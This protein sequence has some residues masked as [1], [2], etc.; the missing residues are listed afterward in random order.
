MNRSIGSQL[1]A[2]LSVS[3]VVLFA[4]VRASANVVL[5]EST[6]GW[7]FS[8]AAGAGFNY[9]PG[10]TPDNGSTPNTVAF[11]PGYTA[12][13]TVD[14]VAGQTYRIIG[15]R[16]VDNTGAYGFSLALNGTT[17]LTELA[18][19]TDLSSGVTV[20]AMTYAG[21]YTAPTTTNTVQLLNGGSSASRVDYL[22]F[23]PTN[24]VF[25]DEHTSDLAYTGTAGSTNSIQGSIN[26]NA[27]DNGMALTGSGTVSGTVTLAP[28]TLYNVYASRNVHDT[29]NLGFRVNL[30]GNV[31]AL[32]YA[33]PDPI[34]PIAY[35]ND[36]AQEVL[37]G[38]FTA[39]SASTSVLLDIGGAYYARVDYLRFE[40]VPE[41]GCL[42]L[43]GCGSLLMTWRRKA[44]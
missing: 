44:A 20:Q 31:L 38:Q 5:D 4:G 7:V 6:P 16:V 28:G 2:A 39:A 21:Y 41:P 13:N 10:A 33:F 40:A 15:S 17:V 12:T 35:P 34:S 18:L 8:S 9:D 43:L 26:T 37:L 24:D 29:G 1:F 30:D 42:A 14:L 3:G 25:F 11:I 19:K 27:A 22:E 23:V 36:W 32:D